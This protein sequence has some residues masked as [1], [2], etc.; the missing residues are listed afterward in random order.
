MRPT[1]ERA[2]LLLKGLEQ[3]FRRLAL[4]KVDGGDNRRFGARVE[5]EVG[6]RVE[7]A[8]HRNAGLCYVW[9]ARG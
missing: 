2:K 7:V 9:L 8:Q 6:W 5:A 1:R 3:V 4:L